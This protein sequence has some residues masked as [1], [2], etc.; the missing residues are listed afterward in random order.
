MFPRI[1]TFIDKLDPAEKSELHLIHANADLN[2]DYEELKIKSVENPEESI[3]ATSWFTARKRG[4]LANYGTGTID[5]ALMAV[6]K[7]RHFFLR[8]FGLA[9]KLIVLDEIHAYDA[10]MTEEIS[11]LIGWLPYC[12]S[13]VVLL[14]ATLPNSRRQQ[15]LESFAPGTT[16]DL[17][18]NYP[19]VIGVDT[20]GSLQ[21][22]EIKELE[23]ATVVI[24]PIISSQEEKAGKIV[25]LLAEKLVDGGCAACILNTVSE[26]QKVYERVEKHINDAGDLLLFHAR[27]TLEH[28]LKIE[29]RIRKLYGKNGER[30]SKGIVIATQVIEQSLDIDFDFMVSDLAPIDLLLQRAGRLHRHMNVRPPLL[31]DRILHVL[32]PDIQADR[33]DFGG[34]R[35]V[36][37][38]D[39][40]V[41][42]ANLFGEKGR[43]HALKVNIP[44]G[45]SPLIETV[46]GNE[47]LHIS[48]NLQDALDKWIE[49][50]IGTELAQLFA[51]HEA[52][53]ADVRSFL[54]DPNYYII[55]LSNDNDD[56]RMISSRLG[57]PNVTLVVTEEG[58][59]LNV[60]RKEDAKRFYGKSLVTDNT[61]LVRHF[62]K[63]DPPDQWKD[64]ALLRHCRRLA[65]KNGKTELGKKTIS[66]DREFGLRII[67]GKGAKE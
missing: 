10:Y 58:E 57:R 15:L 35:F 4:L 47:E 40:L 36:Y 43:Y 18:V 13:S 9:G 65:L 39:I 3:A 48:N 28:R 6:L 52:S 27:F 33:I 60:H 66:Y 38:P 41:K 67:G 23:P 32:I 26:A 51:A 25:Q 29:D 62:Q 37:F 30:P 45:V 46:Y 17:N 53:L 22:E 24:E 19:C 31:Q 49:E 7:V 50:R 21:Y 55:T 20:T 54:D 11:R 5:Q 42:T 64:V 63:E 8:L 59:V 1:K 14:S 56:E 16:S 12:D 2:Q 61:H 44:Y 34:S